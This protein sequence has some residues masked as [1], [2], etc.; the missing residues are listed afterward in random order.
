MTGGRAYRPPRSDCHVRPT[1]QNPGEGA[2]A[3]PVARR[4]WA[5]GQSTRPTSSP[6]AR[7][8]DAPAG[9][10]ACPAPSGRRGNS[11][12]GGAIAKPAPRP[13]PR[14][15]V[16]SP[17]PGWAV[18]AGVSSAWPSWPEPG[19]DAGSGGA[20]RRRRRAGGSEPGR[21]P[22]METRYNLKSPGEQGWRRWAAP[23]EW[24][25][26]TP[27]SGPRRCC[28]LTT[29]GSTPGFAVYARPPPAG[30]V[31]AAGQGGRSGT[32]CQ[33]QALAAPR[34]T[35]TLPLSAELRAH[36]RKQVIYR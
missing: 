4:G 35:G 31:Q 29:R 3:G 8:S 33:A 2:D 17:A 20:E 30:V 22:D 12:E 11:R 13:Y 27:D 7:F 6:G 25:G 19:R 1:S 18:S 34:S 24:T 10:G 21:R 36:P 23:S 26:V 28:P 14:H 9:A 5:R 16:L 32:G 15:P